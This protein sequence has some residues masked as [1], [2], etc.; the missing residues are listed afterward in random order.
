MINHFCESNRIYIILR[1]QIYRQSLSTGS[2]TVRDNGLMIAVLDTRCCKS[3]PRHRGEVPV[4]YSAGHLPWKRADD[5]GRADVV[6]VVPR[7]LDRTY[8]RREAHL[9]G[10]FCSLLYPLIFQ[11]NHALSLFSC[12]CKPIA[13]ASPRK[14]ERSAGRQ[15]ERRDLLGLG[16]TEQ[17]RGV[18]P[19]RL[20]PRH[21]VD[22]SLLRVARLRKP[23]QRTGRPSF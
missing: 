6:Q 9:Q 3:A 2:A 17:R 23:S 19:H 11:T 18:A 22:G 20:P 15:R 13:F 4:P 14:E 8:G 21:P 5:R 12:D 7:F 16:S 1:R 10:H